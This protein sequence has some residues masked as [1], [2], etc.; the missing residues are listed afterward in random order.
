MFSRYQFPEDS[1]LNFGVDRFGLNKLETNLF[2]QP[3]LFLLALNVPIFGA[4]FAAIRP[5]QNVEDF[6]QGRG[7]SSAQSAG[8]EQAIEVP[9]R[10]AIRFD[11]QLWMIEQRQRVQG[12]DVGD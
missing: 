10:E 6:A 11:V 9:D 7:F 8:N 4:D 5:L 2:A 1:F 3:K 12:I